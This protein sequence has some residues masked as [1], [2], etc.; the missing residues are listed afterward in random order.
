MCTFLHLAYFTHPNISE[1][2]YGI[3]CISNSFHFIV[4]SYSRGFFPRKFVKNAST[5]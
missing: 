3:L 1:F 5:F 2:V 4:E